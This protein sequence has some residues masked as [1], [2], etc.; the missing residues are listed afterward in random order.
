IPGFRWRP[1]TTAHRRALLA[2]LAMFALLNVTYFYIHYEVR[3]AGL[4]LPSS[5]FKRPAPNA[6]LSNEAVPSSS[7]E[8]PTE[9]PTESPDPSW[10]SHQFWG[11]IEQLS[12]G[13]GRL[14]YPVENTSYLPVAHSVATACRSNLTYLF[15]VH[16]ASGHFRHRNILRKF[17]GDATLMSRYNW[18]IVFFLGLAQDAKTTNNVLEEAAHTGDIVV[19]PYMDT[20]RNLTYKYV[21]GMK[22]TMD[23]CPSAKYI[24]K[25]DDDIVLNLYKL[26]GYLDQRTESEPPAFHCCVW[27]G[28]PVL[29]HTKSP[30][31]LSKKLYPKNVFPRYC[32]G[33]TVIFRSSILR[34]LYNASF[35]VPFLSVDDALV[36]GEMAKIAGVSHVSLNKYY[37]F[38]GDEW[39]KVVKGTIIFGHIHGEKAR[40]RAWKAVVKELV[41]KRKVVPKTSNSA[42]DFNLV[43]TSDLGVS[44]TAGVVIART[45]SSSVTTAVNRVSRADNYT[46]DDANGDRDVYSST[47]NISYTRDIHVMNFTALPMS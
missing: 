27:D 39:K 31:Y 13:Y 40:V 22:W 37:S 29:R 26:L 2:T 19:F 21:Y 8:V 12:S 38:S 43:G 34:P 28:M 44:S 41:A 23:N 14:P 4:S 11:P 18:S 45:E 24:V 25:M 7:T 9:L 17:I 30:W 5:L 10:E 1:P 46:A 16:T 6:S 35:R 33:S 36:T 42:V 15:F 3:V 32:S 20:Y 47:D